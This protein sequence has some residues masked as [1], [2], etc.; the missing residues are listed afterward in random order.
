MG[1]THFNKP[2]PF[3]DVAECFVKAA[4]GFPGVQHQ[5][6]DP[7]FAGGRFGNGHEAAADSFSLP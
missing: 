7:R 6:R 5:L 4:Y 3:R 1:N 2:F